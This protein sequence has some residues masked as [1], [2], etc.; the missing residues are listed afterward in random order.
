MQTAV[1]IAGATLEVRP[2]EE[3]DEL[4]VALGLAVRERLV[5]GLGGSQVVTSTDRQ[6]CFSNSA[7]LV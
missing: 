7:L 5:P 2:L 3:V 6:D 4:V 1:A